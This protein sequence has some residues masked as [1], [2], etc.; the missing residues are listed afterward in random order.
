MR[1]AAEAGHST[2]TDLADWLAAK[3]DVPFREAHQ[4]AGRAVAAAEAKGVGLAELSLEEL[5][6][7]D[8]RIGAEALERLTVEASV[9]SRASAGGTA[10]ERV[11]E[12][13]AAARAARRS[14]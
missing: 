3:A 10:P 8:T 1:A 14:Q 13:I 9:A 5:Q 12:A 11:I 6:A 2:A 7:I 4:I